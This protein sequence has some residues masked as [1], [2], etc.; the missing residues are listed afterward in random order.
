MGGFKDET[1]RFDMVLYGLIWFY[2]IQHPD[3]QIDEQPHIKHGGFKPDTWEI[4]QHRCEKSCGKL[5]GTDL[6]SWCDLSRS[7]CGFSEG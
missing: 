3:M 4:H 5:V 7:A 2:M 6:D 1:W